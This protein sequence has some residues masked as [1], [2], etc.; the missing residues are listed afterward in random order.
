MMRA[1][2]PRA[3]RAIPSIRAKG[4]TVVKAIDVGMKIMILFAVVAFLFAFI[5][6]SMKVAV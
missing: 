4:M 6:A 1:I 5:N 2:T 3:A